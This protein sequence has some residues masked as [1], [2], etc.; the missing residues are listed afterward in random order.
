MTELRTSRL[1]FS[2]L[3]KPL[4][5]GSWDLGAGAWELVSWA[6]AVPGSP[7]GLAS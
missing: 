3:N 2:V 4:G 1:H 7:L 5:L 6:V